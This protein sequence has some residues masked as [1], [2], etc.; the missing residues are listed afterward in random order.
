VKHDRD[1]CAS[2]RCDESASVVRS[3]RKDKVIRRGM[4]GAKMAVRAAD[5][6]ERELN[7]ESQRAAES[8]SGTIV[9]PAIRLN[10]VITELADG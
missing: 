9:T 8:Y 1:T 10:A 4:A 7:T 2:T 5:K 3:Y 6:A